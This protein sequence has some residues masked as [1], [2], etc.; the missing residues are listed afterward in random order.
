M[1][2]IY[3]NPRCSKSRQ[4]LALLEEKGITPTIIDYLNSPPSAATLHQVLKQ[5]GLTPRELL[6]KGEVVY[7]ELGLKD[8]AISDDDLIKAMTENPKLIERPIVIHD[9]QAKLGRPPEAV[10]TLF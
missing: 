10:L 3:H 9:G 1:T 2:D 6:R 7:K 4:T 8:T 5:L